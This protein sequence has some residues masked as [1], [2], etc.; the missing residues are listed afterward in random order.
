MKLK[1]Q[2]LKENL[3]YVSELQIGE[4][5]FYICFPQKYLKLVLFGE[6]QHLVLVL[7]VVVQGE[8]L[9]TLKRSFGVA[10]VPK[11][12]KKWSNNEHE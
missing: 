12:M 7:V 6:Q 2:I 10:E 11:I 8:V 9:T 1:Y 5:G 3:P 4:T